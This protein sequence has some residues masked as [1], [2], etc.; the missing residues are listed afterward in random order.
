MLFRKTFI[1]VW[2]R[3]ATFRGDSELLPW[4]KAI[5]TARSTA[6]VVISIDILHARQ[7]FCA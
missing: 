2:Q 7:T 1:K 5:L 4:I 3:C 6:S